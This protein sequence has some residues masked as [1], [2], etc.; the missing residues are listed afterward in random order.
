MMIT[1][2]CKKCH[3]ITSIYPENDLCEDCNSEMIAEYRGTDDESDPEQSERAYGD[4]FHD[5]FKSG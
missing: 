4:S 5:Y 3:K 2:E 1:G